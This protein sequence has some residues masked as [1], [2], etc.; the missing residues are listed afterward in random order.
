MI[1]GY[2]KIE[3]LRQRSQLLG[4]E[5]VVQEKVD[6]S[7][8]VFGIN[9]DTGKFRAQTRR[10]N[11]LTMDDGHMGLA[12]ANLQPQED[13][14]NPNWVY[15]GECLTKRKHNRIAYSRIPRGFLVL[16][17]IFDSESGVYIP[18]G[19][20]E[21]EAASLGIEVVPELYS[22]PFSEMPT[23]EELLDRE[24]FLEGHNIEGVVI[25]DYTNKSFFKVV[26]QEFQEISQQKRVRT[27]KDSDQYLD[28]LFDTYR[29]ESRWHKAMQHLF[30]EG[31]LTGTMR[32]VGPLLKELSM[33]FEEEC[34]PLL[35]DQLYNLFRKRA[36]K[37]VSQGFAEWYRT[38]IGQD[39]A[40]LD[41][42]D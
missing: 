22:G 32:D 20:L 39:P 30:E 35:K 2:G 5:L 9:E 42:S 15:F 12:V 29:T 6:G 17:D 28:D 18:R 14:L 11:V 24:S 3:T 38:Q 7:Q 41:N 13:K 37:K 27:P 19:R 31:Q 36:I 40:S 23:F 10:R 34:K 21:E 33:D 8:F 26:S 4:R 25:K 1:Q 16:F